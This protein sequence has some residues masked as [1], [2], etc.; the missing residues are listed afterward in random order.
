M[1][2][3]AKSGGERTGD[4]AVMTKAATATDETEFDDALV[5]GCFT[6]YS[7]KINDQL[8]RIK[9]AIDT[10]GRAAA[11][12]SKVGSQEDRRQAQEAAELLI[13]EHR[14]LKF[15]LDAMV[16]LA[17]KGNARAYR[18][19]SDTTDFQALIENTV[20]QLKVSKISRRACAGD[21]CPILFLHSICL[22][23]AARRRISQGEERKSFKIEE[24]PLMKVFMA[25]AAQEDVIEQ[26]DDDIQ[27]ETTRANN[28]KNAKCPLS[29]RDLVDLNDPVQDSHGFVYEREDLQLYM[30]QVRPDRNGKY[31]CPVAASGTAFTREEIVPA[32]AVIRLQRHRKGRV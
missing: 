10:L 16:Y 2:D 29:L 8:D 11:I 7:R 25:N 28:F 17:S 32:E 30:K 27:V 9:D 21:A 6:S 15:V 23:N 1:S 12:A 13:Q 18:I 3:Q 20:V 19:S 26:I 22:T 4:V 5:V 31:P 24:H 14:E